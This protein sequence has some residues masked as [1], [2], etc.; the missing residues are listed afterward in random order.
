M[1]MN[2]R[3]ML[4]AG[5]LSLLA[6]VRLFGQS[7]AAAAGRADVPAPV[8]RLLGALQRNRLAMTIGDAPAGA[9]WDWLVKE[10]SSARFTL[11]GEE[12]GVAETARF[13][14]ALFSALRGSGYDRLAFELSPAMSEIVEA[15]ARRDGLKGITDVL[16]TPGAFTFYNLREEVQFLA[17]VIKAA[18][19]NER[20]LWGLDREIFSDRYLISRLEPKVPQRAREA[21]NHLKQSSTNAWAKFEQ[22]KNPDDMFILAEDPALVTAL[23]TAWPNPDHESETIMR[24]LEGSLAIETAE[25]TGWQMAIL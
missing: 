14:S 9:G 23:Q 19:R 18:P 12:H 4:F 8:A 5:G 21:F 6:G 16:T 15:A 7:A 24:T 17:D 13:S 3:E 2:R 1:K 10:A 25:R 11:I 22:T 20:V